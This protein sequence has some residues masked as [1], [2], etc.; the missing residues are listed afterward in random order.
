MNS[1]RSATT[2]TFDLYDIGGNRINSFT[3]RIEPMSLVWFSLV[4]E[5]PELANRRGQIKIS[6]GLFSS[7]PF[8][9]QFAGNGAFTA[10]PIVHTYGMR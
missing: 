6:G 4:G 8:S 2:I 10:L 5:H 1:G 9:L 7:A 3:K